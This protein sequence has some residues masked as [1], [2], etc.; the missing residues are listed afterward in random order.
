[1]RLAAALD[2]AATRADRNVSI[3]TVS[4]GLPT[5]GKHR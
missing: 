2:R 5:L 1:M 4:G 3:R